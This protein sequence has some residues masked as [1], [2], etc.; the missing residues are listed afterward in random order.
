ASAAAG[1]AETVRTKAETFEMRA[2]ARLE[3]ASTGLR[4]EAFETLETGLAFRI[5]LAA[6]ECL[7][8]IGIAN[9]FVSGVEFGEVRGSL[10]VVLIGIRVQ[11][12][13]EPAIGA[14][15]VRLARTL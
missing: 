4:A 13:R 10:G 12:F 5:N 1:A 2:A 14:L 9:D 11:F 8:L 3:A 6:V 15:D 7:A